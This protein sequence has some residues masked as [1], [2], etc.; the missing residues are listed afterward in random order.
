[1]ASKRARKVLNQ[2]F[3]VRI[4]LN[5]GNTCLY[6]ANDEF[7]EPVEGIHT[8]ETATP[9]QSGR[10]WNNHGYVEVRGIEPRSIAVLPGLLR[11]Q[12]TVSPLDPTD[13]ASK[14]V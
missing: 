8:L 10:G 1:L 9:A 7:T 12:L 13:H 3:F 11:A 4:Y 14:S 6:V 5:T 2:A